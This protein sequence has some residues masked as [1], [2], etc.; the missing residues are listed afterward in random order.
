MLNQSIRMKS[1]Q[2][3]GSS[4]LTSNT[5]FLTFFEEIKKIVLEEFTD[6]N[7]LIRGIREVE[8]LIIPFLVKILKDQKVKTFSKLPKLF[9]SG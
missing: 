2:R 4:T 8:N 5:L 3:S 9:K 6:E 1:Q 7:K